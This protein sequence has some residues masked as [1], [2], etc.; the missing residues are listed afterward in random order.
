MRVLPDI[1]PAETSGLS[2]CFDRLAAQKRESRPLS[3]YRLQF[4]KD[5]RFDDAR[6]LVGYLRELGISHVYSSPI[7]KARPGSTHGYDISDHNLLNPEIGTEE[8]FRAFVDELK[9][10]GMGQILDVVPNHMG[11]GQG[12]NPWWQDVLENG[13]TAKHADFFDI[14]W[15]PL[16]VELRDKVLLPILAN[17]YGEE[18]EAGRIRLTFNY[19]RGRFEIEYYDKVFPVD[20]QTIPMI[21]DPSLRSGSTNGG[22]ALGAF[23]HLLHELQAL[24]PNTERRAEAA[25]QRQQAAPVLLDRLAEIIRRFPEVRQAMEQ[26][27]TRITGKPGYAQSFD[28]LHRLLEAQA[29]RLAH[30]RVSAEEINYR[31][32]FD[33]N[34]L[35]G[36]CM[37]NPKVFAA[38]HKLLR[39]LLA[40]GSVSGI[41]IDHCDGLLNP[42]QHLVRVQMLYAASQCCGPVPV[43]PLAENGIEAAVQ[44]AFGQHD[45]MNQQAPLYAV[46]EKIL[47]PGEEFPT[48]WPVDGTSGYDFANLVN[49]IFIQSENRQAFT[50]IYERFI[51]ERLDFDSLL[52]NSKKLIMNTALSSEVNVLTHVLDI[53][54]GKDRR[55][56][57][58]TRK[59][60]RD[61]IRETIACF[62]VY[63]TYIDER[64]EV[65]E[66]DAAYV[67]RAIAIAKRRNA[68]TAA[69]VFD[70]LRDNLLLKNTN[71]GGDAEYALKLH[72]TLKFQQLT[73]PVM[74]KGLED[75][76]CYVYNRFISV[77]E[78]GGSPKLF[79]HPVEEFHRGNLI[80]AER[81]PFSLLAT[82][83]HDTKR[84]EDVRAR[85]DVLSEM[86]KVW[87]TQVGRWRRLNEAKK[88]TLADGRQAPDR[89]EEYL[90]YQTLVGSWP[91]AMA[92]EEER[93]RYIERITQYMVKAMHE[94]KINLSWI[95]PDPEYVEAVSKFI[96][97]T[98]TPGVP[99]KNSFLRS[100]GEFL[101][102]VQ[103]FGAINSLSQTLL[104][105]TSPG[106]PDIYQGTEMWDFS[107]V[108]PDNRRPVDFNV[109]REALNNVKERMAQDLPAL[110]Q[111]LLQNYQD[112]RVKL[113]TTLLAME[114]RSRNPE[115]FRA[116][117]YLPLTVT[118]EK[119]EHVAAFAR[120]YQSPLDGE[121]KVA[122]VAVPRFAHTLMKGRI[123]AP[124]GET[125]GDTEI[126][127]T[128]NTPNLLE[129]IFTGEAIEVS[130]RRTIACQ[131]VFKVFPLGLLAS[132]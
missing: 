75:T 58:F 46:V 32:F 42:R 74:A 29:Y 84:S 106:V 5:F 124:I 111:E 72:F 114:F 45:W 49:G 38:T 28:A 110:A 15:D 31:R 127:V 128:P 50:T 22:S 108:D 99:G 48:E 102:A 120:E 117:R 52:Y 37:E 40:E 23:K 55:A 11:V 41:R 4:N 21:F 16:K 76:V 47:E 9:D 119:S 73:G 63:R 68:G 17:Q 85:L 104:K 25:K 24:P 44:S 78:V 79:G 125:W 60:L 95:N 13:Q 69:A 34:D 7:L 96:R 105:I 91:L 87:S 36:L 98:L 131:D 18:L 112:G 107:L 66:R 132:R 88:V 30:W 92:T 103:F 83:T 59:A 113:F 65:N 129:N 54:S 2:E 19:E 56:R 89:N 1:L 12:D 10:H 94:A 35:V 97:Q 123:A 27:L 6:A 82:S 64:G 62:P 121:H 109:R 130:N 26:A 61:A 77:N 81:W 100:M 33:I 20:P 101:P 67:N 115:L 39:R 3:T 126:Q 90:L 70:F 93:E 53:I 71:G 118:G 43:P 122:I 57:D 80:R 116:S 86:P 14:D 51:G 8:E